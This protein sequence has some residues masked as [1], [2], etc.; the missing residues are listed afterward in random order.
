MNF[1]RKGFLGAGAAL[2]AS[3]GLKSIADEE[4]VIQ[5]FDET[6][7]GRVSLD[8]W[9]PFS[10]RV[11]KVGIAGEG[12]CDFGSAFG[13]QS[14]PNIEVVAC[15]D[16]DPEKCRLLQERTGAK[17]TYTSCED[18]ICHASED[19]L[20]AVYIATDAPS[21]CRLAIMALEHGLHVAS[22]V[23]AIFGVEQLD[24]IPKL[25]EAA[26]K[27]GKVYMMNETTAFRYEAYAMR[28][29]YEAGK[30]GRIIYTEGEYFH[31][32]GNDVDAIMCGSYNNWR[33]GCPP[34]YY[35]TH[36]NGFYTCVTHKRF[37]DVSCS[38]VPSMLNQYKPENNSYRNA[39]GS[40]YAMMRCEDG[41][42]ARMLVAWDA[43]AKGGEEGRIWGQQGC[44]IPDRGGY[45]G[46]FEEEVAQMNIMK[47]QLPPGMPCGGHGGSHGY[48]TDD[49]IRAI[50][51]GTKPCVDI[52]TALDTTV[53][54]IYAHMSALKDGE[55]LKIPSFS[56]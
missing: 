32:C 20:E 17:K 15:T 44:Y 35:P 54:G 50:I 24:L 3:A 51:L 34:Q 23:P 48:L 30:F 25:L 5:G 53:A 41:S 6:E 2:F 36:S 42:V 21:H 19:G 46:W 18:M 29:I 26:K 31:P 12:V 37:T 9:Q 22:A 8:P 38:A 13:Y 27:S 14:H 33:V 45:G 55:T 4:K 49:F 10:D 43:P 16:L 56:L 47:P 1:T 28:K 40:E 11:V 39:F 52:I 7:A